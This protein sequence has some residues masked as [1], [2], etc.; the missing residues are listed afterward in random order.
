VTEAL[1]E[2]KAAGLVEIGRRRIRV[3]D[4]ARLAEIA[5]T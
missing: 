4:D 1:R 2:L 3:L 5:D